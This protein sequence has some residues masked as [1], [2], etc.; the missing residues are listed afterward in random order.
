M[1]EVFEEYRGLLFSI[2]YRMLGTVADSEDVVQDTWLRWE[3]ARKTHAE[4]GEE[5]AE[6]RAYL[7]RIATNLSLNRLRSAATRRETYVGPWLPEPLVTSVDASVPVETADSVSLALL[8]VLESLSPLERAVFVLREAFGFDYTEIAET[9]GRTPEAVRQLGHRARSHVQAR[10]PRF[11]AS[12]AEHRR[13]TEEF[14]SACAGGDL[15]R[16]MDLLAPDVTV[17]SDGGGR[18]RAALRPVHGADRAARWMLG[19]LSREKSATVVRPVL[20]NGVLGVAFLHGDGALDSVCCLE[21][22]EG[23]VTAV[24][25]VR[26]PEKLGGVRLG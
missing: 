6:P 1:S 25:I 2:A 9:L 13:V 14:L 26:N 23:R 4:T 24:R 17:W 11:E 20:V 10:R 22:A 5:I 21:V 19:V 15:A 7:A 16:M 18:V 12:A 8:V 3:A